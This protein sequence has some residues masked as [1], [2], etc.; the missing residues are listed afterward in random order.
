MFPEL[1]SGFSTSKPAVLN[2]FMV[3]EETG[4]PFLYQS[5]LILNVLDLS[6]QPCLLASFLLLSRD[7]NNKFT[8]YK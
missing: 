3:N 1:K 2:L 6:F 8:K 7:L 5:S 4:F